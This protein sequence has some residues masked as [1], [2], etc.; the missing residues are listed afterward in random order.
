MWLVRIIDGKPS[1][2]IRMDDSSKPHAWRTQ[3]G[4]AAI[5]Q[6]PEGALSSARNALDRPKDIPVP[7]DPE[8]AH[9]IRELAEYLKQA[10]KS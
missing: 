1:P 5:S 4:A 6:S 3:N 10:V 7:D 8:R 2:A 9:R